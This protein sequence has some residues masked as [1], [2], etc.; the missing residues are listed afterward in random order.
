MPREAAVLSEDFPKSSTATDP[1]APVDAGAQATASAEA[2]DRAASG[3]EAAPAEIS[4][5][6]PTL[7]SEAADAT[8]PTADPPADDAWASV[9]VPSA[10]LP[11]LDFGFPSTPAAGVESAALPQEATVSAAADPGGKDAVA[12]AAPPDPPAPPA[13]SSVPMFISRA[14]GGQDDGAGIDPHKALA[15]PLADVAFE[16]TSTLD[17]V[18]LI[19]DLTGATITVTP[20]AFRVM[21]QP[22]SA[23]VATRQAQITAGEVLTQILQER[24]LRLAAEDGHLLVIPAGAAGE[25]PSESA[26]SAALA[27]KLQRP[28]T[29]TFTVPTPLGDIL[30][31]VEH[32]QGLTLLVDWSTLAEQR[33]APESLVTTSVV[34]QPLD[35]VLDGLL[36]QLGLRWSPLDDAAVWITAP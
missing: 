10:G 31:H 22:A 16:G 15:L 2:L 26:P 21:R 9:D 14:N 17:V 27:E 5:R 33:L 30:R 8:P 11:Q 36:P 4:A 7:P 18:R 35:E 29:F 32:S 34:D 24:G 20:A 28:V 13:S 25:D 12:T 3:S 1:A 19:A 23:P 6:P